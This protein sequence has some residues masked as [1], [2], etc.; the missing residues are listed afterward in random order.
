M[1]IF[2]ARKRKRF[3]N[4]NI[5]FNWKL[6]NLQNLFVCFWKVSLSSTVASIKST[7]FQNKPDNINKNLKILPEIG[8]SN[9][10]KF[11]VTYL[12]KACRFWVKNF[13]ILLS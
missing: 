2:L 11:L 8:R 6:N 9:L 10:L 1:K 5:K 12:C 4:Q 13:V 7:E 3:F